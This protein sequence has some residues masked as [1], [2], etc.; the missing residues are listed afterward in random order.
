MKEGKE[1]NKNTG[2]K[3][4]HHF[5]QRL[6]VPSVRQQV[7]KA[8]GPDKIPAELFKAGGDTVLDTMHRICGDLENWRVTRGMNVL[9]V[10]STSQER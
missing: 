1:L 6:L 7:A 10:Y 9:H 4:L 8:T 5:V 2:S 3:S